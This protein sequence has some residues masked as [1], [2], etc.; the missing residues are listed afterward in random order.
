MKLKLILGVIVVLII[1]LIGV[2]ILSKQPETVQDTIIEEEPETPEPPEPEIENNEPETITPAD[3]ITD[4]ER[5]Y[6]LGVLPI[7]YD[8]QDFNEA[9]SLASESCQLVPVWGR[10]SPYWEKAADLEGQWGQV[11]VEQLTR[12]NGMAPLLHFSFI[13]ENFT[14]SSPEGTE[15]TLSSLEWREEYKQAV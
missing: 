8:G 10:P 9:Y 11:F 3:T 4:P 1:G 14:V 7:P 2:S 15:Y 13:D 5:G 6:L 12:G